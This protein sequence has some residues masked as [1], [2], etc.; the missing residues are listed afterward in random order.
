MQIL[1][2]NVETSHITSYIETSQLIFSTNQ[3][4]GFYMSVILILYRLIH[5]FP[6]HPFSTPWKR[7]KTVRF[8][9]RKPYGLLICP[10]TSSPKLTCLFVWQTKNCHCNKSPLSKHFTW[11]KT[12]EVCYAPA[13]TL[14]IEINKLV[15]NLY[16]RNRLL[17]SSFEKGH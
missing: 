10:V 12:R 7:Q 16:L 6:M 1:T 9:Y 14:L 8:S 13:V 15:A 5:S 11:W 2:T 3:L 17:W 4:N